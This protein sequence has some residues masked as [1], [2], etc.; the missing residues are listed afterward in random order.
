MSKYSK[1]YIHLY[2]MPHEAKE[3]SILFHRSIKH[4]VLSCLLLDVSVGDKI[5]IYHY[6]ILHFLFALLR[7]CFS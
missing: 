7:M 6:K 4:F 3:S 2:V 5:E 1:C